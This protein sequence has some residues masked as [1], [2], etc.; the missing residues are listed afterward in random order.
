MAD[1]RVK[2]TRIK[3]LIETTITELLIEAQTLLDRYEYVETKKLQ[4]QAG[5]SKKVAQSMLVDQIVNEEEFMRTWVNRNRRVIDEMT[6]QLVAQPIN[7][8]A[9]QNPKA[10]FTWVLGTVK[11]E[12]CPDC[13]KLSSMKPRTMSEWRSL[14]YGLPREGGT[15]CNVGCNCML[16]SA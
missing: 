15:A 14:G 5:V 7:D 1:I 2:G 13:L 4:V 6:A 11:T 9:K 10:K 12:H 3:T 8:Y 16:S